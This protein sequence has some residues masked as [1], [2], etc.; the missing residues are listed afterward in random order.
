MPIVD[1]DV[2]FS[3]SLHPQLAALVD[4]HEQWLREKGLAGS[5]PAVQSLMKTDLPLAV[6]WMWGNIPFEDNRIICDTMM[7]AAVFD[8]YCVRNNGDLARVRPVLERVIEIVRDPDAFAP[9]SGPESAWLDIWAR[10][11]EGDMS[12]EWRAR[13]LRDLGDYFQRLLEETEEHAADTWDPDVQTYLRK[14]VRSYAYHM[15]L[16]LG[17]RGNAIELPSA[18]LGSGYIED[19]AFVCFAACCIVNDVVSLEREE[20]EGERNNIVIQLTHGHGMS[21]AHAIAESQQIVARLCQDFIALKSGM[22]AW[23]ESMGLDAALQEQLGR[24]VAMME[25]IMRGNYEWHRAMPGRYL[26]EN[27]TESMQ[28]TYL[29]RIET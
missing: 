17:E 5:E 28:D 15:L 9:Q 8:D 16:D 11:R 14:R 23:C 18:L 22:P 4:A 6:A 29:S 1:F 20:S 24:Y 12:S 10:V 13:F 26:P 19:V 2:P 21:R 3:A 7:W 25:G 27:H